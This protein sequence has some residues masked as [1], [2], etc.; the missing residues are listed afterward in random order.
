MGINFKPTFTAN[1]LMKSI[2]G[3][4]QRVENI[5]LDLLKQTGEEFIIDARS[6]KTYKDRTRNLRGSIGYI[7]MKD[8]EQIFGNFQE[9]KSLK[10]IKES[11]KQVA[12]FVGDRVGREL[13]LKIGE[14]YGSGYALIVVAGMNYA[15]AVEAKGYDVLTGPSVQAEKNFKRAM[16]RLQ[17]S[18]KKRGLR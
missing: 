11:E 1:D 4:V 8:G 10:R 5:V 14:Q 7:I 17:Q 12:E 18:L 9:P 13:A 16:M 6:L 3:Q 2:M 15:A